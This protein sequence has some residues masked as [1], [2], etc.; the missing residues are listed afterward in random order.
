MRWKREKAV[1]NDVLISPYA[2]IKNIF[3]EPETLAFSGLN[4]S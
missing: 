3:V 4:L 1:W 2:N